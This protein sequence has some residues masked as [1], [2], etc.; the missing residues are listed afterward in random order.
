MAQ[1]NKNSSFDRVVFICRLISGI[2]VS[3]GLFDDII[4]IVQGIQGAKQEVTD[5]VDPIKQEAVD[6]IESLQT[7]IGDVASG[8]IDQNIPKIDPK[9]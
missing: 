8:Q 3:M 9:E 1:K 7:N 5:A 6:T 4:G 2:L